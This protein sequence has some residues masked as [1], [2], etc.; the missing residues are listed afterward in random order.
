MKPKGESNPL[1]S[2]GIPVFN[3]EKFLYK[4]LDSVLS[5]TLTDFEL[6]ISDNASTDNTQKICEEYAKKDNRIRYIRQSENR[7]PVWNFNF[8]LNQARSKFFVW[9]SADDFWEPTFLEKNIGIL[10]SSRNVVGSISDVK[11]F[12]KITKNLKPVVVDDSGLPSR[13]QYVYPIYGTY[14]KKVKTLLSFGWAMNS[15]SVFRTKELRK[16]IIQNSFASLDF[17]ILLNLLK[18]GELYVIDEFLLN[19]FTGGITSTES[20]IQLLAK[21]NVGIFGI[22]FPYA[23]FTLWCLKNVG[24]RIFMKNFVWFVWLN[25]RAEKKIFMSYLERLKLKKPKANNLSII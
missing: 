22:I 3:S 14:E 23:K 16:S 21:Q 24:L 19:R 7:G 10:E 5:Q 12:G 18:Y 4:R 6:I 20:Y 11:L 1:V 15:Y 17:A 2:V 25:Y 9:A 8:V 13:Y